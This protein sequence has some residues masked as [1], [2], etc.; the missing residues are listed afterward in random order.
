LLLARQR[1]EAHIVDRHRVPARAQSCRNGP[2]WFRRSCPGGPARGRD[3]RRAARRALGDGAACSAC[4]CRPAWGRR[5]S[6]CY[7]L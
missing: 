1:H 7:S 5:A 2:A 3:A 6:L 4:V